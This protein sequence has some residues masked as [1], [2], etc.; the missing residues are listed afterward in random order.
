[1]IL[2][3]NIS[4][5]I[6]LLGKGIKMRNIKKIVLMSIFISLAVILS[7]FDKMITPLAFPTL[8]TAKI[9][10]ANIVVLLS[11]IMFD[12]KG[13]FIIV[14]L[15]S[16]IA[17]LLIGGLISFIIG[18]TA[19]LVSYFIMLGLYKFFKK[20][21]SAIGISVAGGFTHT[22]SQLFVVSIIYN[23]G[24]ITLY[25]GA[26]LVFVSLITSILIGVIV[27]RLLDYFITKIEV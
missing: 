25:Y 13:S 14:I 3:D 10:F 6:I 17:N 21:L 5:G 26:L 9:G 24:E 16:V 2:S 15:K 12:F 11:I 18:G 7:I 27:N 20:H 8:P 19:S 23:L 4:Y 1:M 22:M